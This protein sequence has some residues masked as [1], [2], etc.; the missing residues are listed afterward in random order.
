MVLHTPLIYCFFYE[1]CLFQKP[2]ITRAGSSEGTFVESNGLGVTLD[3]VDTNKAVDYLASYDWSQIEQWKL[4]LSSLDRSA[5]LYTDEASKLAK[6]IRAKANIE[7]Y[8]TPI[9]S[10]G[11]ESAL[12]GIVISYAHVSLHVKFRGEL[13]LKFA[14]Q[15]RS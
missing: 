13:T 14:L 2:I 9:S 1:A 15:H 5:Y 8:M 7:V 4:S 12:Q 10:T 11:F 3:E 6:L